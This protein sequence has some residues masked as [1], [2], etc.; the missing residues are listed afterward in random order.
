M[1]VSDLYGH[2]Q[3]DPRHKDVMLLAYEEISERRFGGWTMGQVHLTKVHQ[4]TLLRYFREKPEP[5]PRTPCRARPRWRCS[6]S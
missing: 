3:R 6:K 1:Q 2:I 4:A 5:R